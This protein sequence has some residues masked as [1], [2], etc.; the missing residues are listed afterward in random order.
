MMPVFQEKFFDL[1]LVLLMLTSTPVFDICPTFPTGAF[2]SSHA[3][4]TP[5]SRG[6]VRN[7]SILVVVF[8]YTST[9]AS[10]L[11]F[12]KAI[13]IPAFLVTTDSQLRSGLAIPFR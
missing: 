6:P 4:P 11:P 7:N 8:R 3:S 12:I 9:V 5:I 1:I 10:I 13:S 2:R